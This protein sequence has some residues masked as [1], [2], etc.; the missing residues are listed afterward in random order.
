MPA[1][2]FHTR[3]R[4]L[5]ALAG[6]MLAGTLPALPACAGRSSSGPRSYTLPL[7]QLE[8]LIGRKF[9]QRRQLAGL[10]E[11]T[12]LRPRL[13]L[14]PET[15]R[16]GTMIDLLVSEQVVGKRYE[17]SM[18]LD[19]GVRFDASDGSVRMVDVRVGKV[20]FPAMPEQFRPLFARAAPRLAEQSL[21]EMVLHKIEPD[22]LSMVSGLGYR[23]G[24]VRVTREGL[25]VDL[26]PASAA[27]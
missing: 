27:P 23:V 12:L 2:P 16:L 1:F 3:R 26:L 14:L 15:N 24:E 21:N 7:A 19:Y 9:P 20:E 4:S 25:K 8:K 11:I 13:R 5:G 18:D 6:M 17:G 22:Q 10:M